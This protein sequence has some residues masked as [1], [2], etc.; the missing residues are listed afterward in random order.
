M[1]DSNGSTMNY[2]RRPVQVLCVALQT[3]LAMPALSQDLFFNQAADA[4]TVQAGAAIYVQGGVVIADGGAGDAG[5]DL[6][7]RIVVG[8]GLGAIPGQADWTVNNS[9]LG[10]VGGEG[11]AE[12]A[13]GEQQIGG[14]GRVEFGC[15]MF[16]ATGTS[17]RM[18]SNVRIRDSLVLGQANRLELKGRELQLL[19][20]SP[21]AIRWDEGGWLVSETH[22]DMG[23]DYG[24]VYWETENSTDSTWY[25]IPFGTTGPNAPVDFL[26]VPVSGSYLRVSTYGTGIDNL[27]LPAVGR[28]LSL[29]V[30]DLYSAAGGGDHALYTVDRFWIADP[31][32]VSRV[33]RFTYAPGES[34]GG[35]TGFEDEL[36]AQHWLDPVGWQF[37]GSGISNWPVLAS[38][39][40][41]IPDAGAWTLVT[42]S[43]PLPV[44]CR[45][46]YTET[47]PDKVW[48]IWS[49]ETENNNK[50]FYIQR[51][52]ALTDW[53]SLGFVSGAGT[54]SLEQ[55]YQFSDTD[56]P[57]QGAYY[58]LL[59]QDENLVIREAC[60]IIYGKPQLEE[61]YTSR[62]VRLWPN[63]SDG[64]I[65]LA[66]PT[67]PTTPMLFS[68]LD[69]T[70]KIL[71][72]TEM[73]P[74]T[75][76]YLP[77][78]TS[79]EGCVTP[80][81]FPPEISAGIYQLRIGGA[82]GGAFYDQHLIVIQP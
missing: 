63:P 1:A 9:L 11:C 72:E 25:R 20:R 49:T 61:A 24:T 55:T 44:S 71:W 26:P 12:F 3:G 60:G 47:A 48:L 40:A 74:E 22:P 13:A 64:H 4:I 69:L 8:A 79:S 31:G 32:P 14:A 21:L 53:E 35:V 59:Q 17:Y 43:L 52:N 66:W 58:R 50:G 80:M 6:E 28:G 45:D 33:M 56:P 62:K 30:T 57:D 10:G 75:A 67:I 16:T 46:F 34:S 70:G 2:S 23:S 29:P 39:T 38:V 37:P 81:A 42:E 76:T 5:F 54:S 7:G 78:Q 51:R 27:P 18:S 36:F 41:E 68:L 19:N 73:K 65:M 82:L 77:G 15:L